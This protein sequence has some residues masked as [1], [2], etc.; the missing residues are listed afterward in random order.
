[1]IFSV[2]NKIFG[3]FVQILDNFVKVFYE[4]EVIMYYRD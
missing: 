4:K 1:M 3:N 2:S